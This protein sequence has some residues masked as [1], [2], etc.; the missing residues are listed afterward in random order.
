[1]ME[2]QDLLNRYQ[3]EHGNLKKVTLIQISQALMNRICR[4]SGLEPPQLKEPGAATIVGISV[5]VAPGIKDGEINIIE[6]LDDWSRTGDTFSWE[7]TVSFREF[8]T[9]W[10]KQMREMMR[11]AY[12]L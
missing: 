12:G 5:K 3:M 11:K 6:K 1:M 4:D 2:F 9:D 10:E 8:Q 7:S